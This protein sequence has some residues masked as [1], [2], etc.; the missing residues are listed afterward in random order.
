M[1]QGERII[2]TLKADGGWVESER[3]YAQYI[4]NPATR[5]SELRAKGEPIAVRHTP[6]RDAEGRVLYTGSDFK[7][8]GTR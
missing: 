2:A 1:T 7:W 8:E 6:R 5:V 3:F 4:R